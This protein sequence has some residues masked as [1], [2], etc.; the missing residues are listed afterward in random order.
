MEATTWI[1]HYCKYYL[2]RFQYQNL[3][4]LT[5][6]AKVE[7]YPKRQEISMTCISEKA[8]FSNIEDLCFL[9]LY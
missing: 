6:L 9:Q 4:F 7:L 8:R 1:N 5:N 3:T 2:P